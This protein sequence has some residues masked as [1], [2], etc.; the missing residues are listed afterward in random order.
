[1]LQ[2]G[3]MLDTRPP[4]THLQLGRATMN[5]FFLLKETTTTTPNF[6]NWVLN[7]ESRLHSQIKRVLA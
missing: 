7:P 3:G 5:I 2:L 1:M 6:Q 4:G